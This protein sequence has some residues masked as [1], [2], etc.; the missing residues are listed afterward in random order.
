MKGKLL[1]SLGLGG[2]LLALMLGL[3]ALAGLPTA[4]ATGGTCDRYVVNGGNDSWVH[5]SNC[6]HKCSTYATKGTAA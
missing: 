2:L 3:L 6:E 5:L 4:Q 1:L